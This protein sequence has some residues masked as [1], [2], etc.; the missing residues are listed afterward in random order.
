MPVNI[1][2]IS[3]LSNPMGCNDAHE[4]AGFTEFGVSKGIGKIETNRW[5]DE[6]GKRGKGKCVEQENTFRNNHTL[7]KVVFAVVSLR[8]YTS[9]MHLEYYRG[10]FEN[11]FC[12]T[13]SLVTLSSVTTTFYP[14]QSLKRT[15][16]QS[17]ST[18]PI[19]TMNPP[20]FTF[21]SSQCLKRFL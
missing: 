8:A 5:E 10:S 16:T 12:S 18:N 3:H 21:K 9:R 4:T 6:K 11:R 13:P 20:L 19:G 1:S 17:S 15:I 14:S 2:V 7:L